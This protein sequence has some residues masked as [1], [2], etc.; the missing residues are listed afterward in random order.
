M[1]PG[2]VPAAERRLALALLAHLN[3]PIGGLIGQEC[4][5]SPC[6]MGYLALDFLGFWALRGLGGVESRRRMTSGN[7]IGDAVVAAVRCDCSRL[8]LDLPTSES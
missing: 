8:S 1:S 3:P 2:C 6:E 5:K 4:N 7:G